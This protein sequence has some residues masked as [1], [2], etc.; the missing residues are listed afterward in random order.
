MIVPQCRNV[1]VK[2]A[3]TWLCCLVVLVL[4]AIVSNRAPA[5]EAASAEYQVY[6]VR[7]KPVRDV[8][9]MLIELLGNFGDRTHLVADPG[10]NQLLLRGPDAA[11][12]VARQ[13]IQS[14]DRPAPRAVPTKRKSQPEVK[15]Y[16]LNRADEI[17][18]R[19]GDQIL[20]VAV[21]EET[22]QLLVLALAETH[23][24]IA[25]HFQ[26]PILQPRFANETVPT[27]VSEEQP[28]R[29]MFVSLRNSKVDDVVP[30]LRRLF[31]QRLQPVRNSNSNEPTYVLSE[32]AGQDVEISTHFQRNRVT[33]YGPAG[34]AAQLTRLIRALDSRQEADGTRVRILAI[35]RS[36]PRKVEEAVRAYRGEVRKTKPANPRRKNLNDDRSDL[37]F[38]SDIHPVNFEFQDDNDAAP[39]TQLPET[40]EV[41]PEA[42]LDRN[43]ERLREL[44]TDVEVE[45]L[46]D[47]DVIILRGRDRDVEEMTRIINEIERLSAEAEPEIEIVHLKNVDSQ[48][49]SVVV[50]SVL[51]E[52]T[53][54]RQ[55][56]VQITPLVKPNAVMLVGWG[57]A[58]QVLA[59]LIEKLDQPVDPRTQL[60]VFRLEHAPAATTQQTVQQF[61]VNRPGLTATVRVT[62]DLRSNSLIVYAAPSD[63]KDVEL[64]IS[65]LDVQHSAVVNQARII[66]LKNSLATDVAQILT[67]AITAASGTGGARPSAVLELLAID[68]AGQKILKSG[69]LNNVQI[70]PDPRKNTL[71]ISAP[72]ESMELLVELIRQLDE[73]PIDTAQIKVFRIIN[74]EAA[75]LTRMLRSLL[76][77]E[78]GAGS[79][80]Q[81]AVAEGESSLVPLRFA[82]DTRTNSI[83]ATGSAVDLRIIEALLLRLDEKE[84]Q[85]R[86]NV[87]YQ[88][89]NVSSLDV[90]KAVSDFLRSERQ[91][92]QA[93]PG[94]LSPFQ[95]IEREVIVVPEP[96]SNKIIISATPRFYKDIL[97]IV[98]QLD[99]QP[100]QVMIQVLIAEVALNDTD[101]FGIELGLQDS[102]LFDRSLL[103][104]LAD[105]QTL[106]NTAQQSTDQGIITATTQTLIGA[107]TEPGFNFNQ[108]LLG[109][110]GSARSLAT[111]GAVAGQ[112]LSNFA[113]G[114]SNTKLGY[115]GLVLSAGSESVSVLLRA[116]HENRRLE[117]LSR[118]QV[119]TLDNQPAWIQV[120]QR[121]PRITGSNVGV[122][123]TVNSL[124]LEDV[125]LILGVTPRISPEGM[126]VMEI[127]TEKSEV[128]SDVDG[129]P[130][131]VS[132]DGTIVKSPKINV[133]NAQ[134]TVSAADGETIILGGLIT[135]RTEELRRRVP[136]LAD[137]P[138]LG[139]LFRYD[140][141]EVRRAE[142]LIIL[143]PHVINSQEDMERVKMEEYARMSW[144]ATDVCELHN[145][146][147]LLCGEFGC[148]TYSDEIPVIYPDLDPRG[149]S[150]ETLQPTPE[151]SITLPPQTNRRSGPQFGRPTV[152]SSWDDVDTVYPSQNP[153]GGRQRLTPV[154]GAEQPPRI[155]RTPA[156]EIPPYDSKQFSDIPN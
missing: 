54:G 32:V 135:K 17:K 134:T 52:L 80:P 5:Q 100:P 69:L 1:R 31:G 78:T 11:Q 45:T 121:V 117:V 152:Q 12:Q 108:A 149:T 119:M 46:P 68:P 71:I 130:V 87:V 125:G 70:T 95:Q 122:T 7:H 86:Q 41:S 133:I 9:R 99:E 6:S 96:V 147:S 60:R 84:V 136:Y 42:E 144:C 76:P 94:G 129:I 91:I 88:L 25:Q 120:G 33:I 14:V 153:T 140:L 24:Q 113:V 4:A 116:L 154:R 81:L 155:L 67:Q 139:H 105:S 36:D 146:D 30:M 20:R 22:S 59:G 56:R 72:A 82:I 40:D 43:R 65:R 48:Q 27:Q 110:S 62:S 23:V 21:D 107:T 35:S 49:L 34:A 75:D 93:S 63:M 156:D 79:G 13:L 28:P 89:K 150:P 53:G 44:G 137:V 19:F 15:A 128:G 151:Q 10:K 124:T 51:Q 90:S 38:E 47:L 26:D 148:P 58:M 16:Q 118:P 77:A 109:N 64:L 101:E 98:E 85:H 97:A 127:D 142:L 55:G 57:E 138:L 37:G 29:E 104:N 73:T 92:Q 2:L 74:G 114:R 111:A 102:L 50:K 112:A 66:P 39:V 8:E 83:I 143:T 145:H 106:T 115:G 131:L 123:G 61:F 18:R 126:V 3:G 103:S 141:E 132:T